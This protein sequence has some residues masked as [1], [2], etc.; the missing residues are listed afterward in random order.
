MGDQN[1]HVVDTTNEEGLVDVFSEIYHRGDYLR[2]EEYDSDLLKRTRW[3]RPSTAHNALFGESIILLRPTSEVFSMHNEH[4]T[5]WSTTI[6]MVVYYPG[7]MLTHNFSFRRSNS[8]SNMITMKGGEITLSN[9]PFDSTIRHTL[10]SEHP[11]ET[12]NWY[13][14]ITLCIKRPTIILSSK[15][16]SSTANIASPTPTYWITSIVVPE[17][18]SSGMEQADSL[19]RSTFTLVPPGGYHTNEWGVDIFSTC[20]IN[21]LSHHL[22][23][24]AQHQMLFDNQL[25]SVVWGDFSR[26]T[27]ALFVDLLLMDLSITQDDTMGFSIK[28]LDGSCS[29]RLIAHHVMMHHY[30]DSLYKISTAIIASPIFE[31]SGVDADSQL[32]IFINTDP[33]DGIGMSR[34]VDKSALKTFIR[35]LI[36]ESYYGKTYASTCLDDTNVFL[37]FGDDLYVSIASGKLVLVSAGSISPDDKMTLY[38]KRALDTRCVISGVNKLWISM[39][40]VSNRDDHASIIALREASFI[41]GEYKTLDAT[42]LS[43]DREIPSTPR[44][45]L[46][47]ITLATRRVSK[48]IA[49]NTKL[50]VINGDTLAII[51]AAG[52]LFTYGES[53]INIVQSETFHELHIRCVEYGH[54]QV[55]YKSFVTIK[56]STRS[57]YI[58]NCRH[59]NCRYP[60]IWISCLLCRRIDRSARCVS[61][62]QCFGSLLSQ[63]EQDS[64]FHDQSLDRNSHPIVEVTSDY[65]YTRVHVT[66]DISFA[67][68]QGILSSD[69]HPL[70]RLVLLSTS[71]TYGVDYEHV[72]QAI[73]SNKTLPTSWISIPLRV[74]PACVAPQ[75]AGDPDSY[76]EYESMIIQ[77]HHRIMS[78]NPT[79]GHNGISNLRNNRE[80]WILEHKKTVENESV[81]HDELYGEPLHSKL[82]TP[83]FQDIIPSLL[84]W[85]EIWGELWGVLWGAIICS[86]AH[87]DELGS[88]TFV[89]VPILYVAKGT[90][91]LWILSYL[92][93]HVPIIGKALLSA[94]IEDRGF[95]RHPFGSSKIQSYR[96]YLF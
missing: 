55:I 78:T 1:N 18:H 63:P 75:S 6:G 71:T 67:N 73:V 31:I 44:L 82:N 86:F 23:L 60:L 19:L 32:C 7:N 4:A 38:M 52:T 29:Y 10:A 3:R 26:F 85:E 34:A 27:Y 83:T 70:L 64:L 14:D 8:R 62:D 80:P 72:P 68:S 66:N 12:L 50:T 11:H 96:W 39:L 33:I 74:M 58:V 56:A 91:Y 24:I 81:S 37:L 13:E 15:D 41:H 36:E 25:H 93:T 87:F 47:D 54:R 69:V 79:L 49:N 61:C 21:F 22:L 88:V 2:G 76:E 84:N 92:C 16:T 59:R 94:A 48:W 46:D 45:I 9:M 43:F 35:F 95:W 40:L 57:C 5:M 42:F 30:Q 17:T 51:I 89:Q 90:M 20:G 53:N 77:E 28:T 65:D